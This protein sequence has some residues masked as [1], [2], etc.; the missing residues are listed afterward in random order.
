MWP[1]FETWRGGL[2]WARGD[3]GGGGGWSK[4]EE[5]EEGW[6]GLEE[7]RA[8]LSFLRRSSFMSAET[9][10]S[11]PKHRPATTPELS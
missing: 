4:E 10:F 5:E 8:S 9:S 3:T 7:G 11:Q 2:E 6:R 1:H